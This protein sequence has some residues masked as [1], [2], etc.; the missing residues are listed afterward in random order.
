LALSYV[1]HRRTIADSIL[2]E[3]TG[4]A[5]L[6]DG[7]NASQWTYIVRLVGIDNEPMGL[8]SN[9]VTLTVYRAM[10]SG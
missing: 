4:T 10:V 7:I 6:P 1:V 3:T 9:E 8:P 2:L 5:E